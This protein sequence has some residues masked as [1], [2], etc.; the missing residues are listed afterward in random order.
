MNK[1]ADSGKTT[2]VDQIQSRVCE[3]TGLS[4]STVKHILKENEHK[5]VGKESSTPTKK[6]KK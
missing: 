1:E 3:A 2:N 4:V 5:R 6:D